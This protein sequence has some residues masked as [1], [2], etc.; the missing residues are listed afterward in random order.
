MRKLY[1]SLQEKVGQ[2]IV[3]IT[4]EITNDATYY[5]FIVFYWQGDTIVSA[6]VSTYTIKMH[7]KI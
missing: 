3:L 4:S 6:W 2:N 7:L 1:Y 5:D